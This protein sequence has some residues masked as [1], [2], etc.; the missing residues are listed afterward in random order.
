M[1][2][3][4][5]CQCG[6]TTT[7]PSHMAA[8]VG[9]CCWDNTEWVCCNCRKVQT[10]N[11][12]ECTIFDLMQ[13]IHNDRYIF[14]TAINHNPKC[15]TLTDMT[16]YA[17]ALKSEHSIVAVITRLVI[18]LRTSMPGYFLKLPVQSK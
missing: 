3:K 13:T 5:L 14:P 15:V 8:H 2:Q 10:G 16:R 6:Y 9:I 4:L 11:F 12:H 18:M 17:H 7:R 1:G